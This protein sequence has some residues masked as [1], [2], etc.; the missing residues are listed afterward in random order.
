MG[1]KPVLCLLE[2]YS[3][4]RHSPRLGLRN[5]SKKL[6]CQILGRFGCDISP[7]HY[8]RKQ[9]RYLIE[10]LRT[11]NCILNPHLITDF[12]HS[13]A[14]FL[15]LILLCF[16]IYNTG[17]VIPQVPSKVHWY[18][19]PKRA[20]LV[21]NRESSFPVEGKALEWKLLCWLMEPRPVGTISSTLDNARWRQDPSNQ[22]PET[23]ILGLNSFAFQDQKA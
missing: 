14:K 15:S 6:I 16:L 10:F 8:L 23:A 18:L 7:S 1:S 9:H 3:E 19:W 22:L 17:L 13:W 4:T 12:L 21:L 11:K 5:K 20:M 2:D